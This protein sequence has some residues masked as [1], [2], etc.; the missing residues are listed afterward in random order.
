MKVLKDILY[1][2]GL[3]EVIGSTNI[4]I[5][6]ITFNSKEVK[7]DSLFVAVRGY[8][9]DGH[10]Y[11]SQAIEAGAIAI[12]CEDFPEIT[13]ANINYIKVENSALALGMIATNFYDNPSENIKLV[14][15]TGTNGK[16]TTVTL[17]YHLFKKLGYK[18]G[19]ISTVVNK[20]DN[21]DI[22]STHTTPDPIKLNALL[23]EMIHEG[24][25]Y[26]FM[27]VSSH[28]V[29]QKRIAGLK[30]SVAGFT[31]LSHDHLDYH[32][33]FKDYLL[34]KKAFF[35]QLSS[36]AVAITN[37]DDKNGNVMVQNTKAAVKSYALFSD[38][39]YKAKLIESH[40]SGL[41]IN[42]D[43][44]EIWSK[45]VGTFNAYNL[46]LVYGI[47]RSLNVEKLELLRIISLLESVEGRFQYFKSNNDVTVI[48]DYAH[49]PDAL[50][51]VLNSIKNLRTG[52]E[53]LITIV[54]C[55]GNRDAEKRP[56]MSNI[57][58]RFSNKVIITS[59]N[60]RNEDPNDIIAQM[61]KG[62]E[63]VDFK[64]TLSLVD[65][66]DAIKTAVMMAES[67]DIIL[68]AGKG[69]EKYQEISGVKYPFDDFEIA[70]ELIN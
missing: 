46:L 55:G 15:V 31:N 51:N 63:P 14:G 53:K 3:V 68:I 59:D 17:C 60:P 5:S 65:R 64:K 26:C 13:L 29:D 24:C 67:G 19:L 44:D 62:V 37:I 1:K 12:V 21:K 52:N 7:R 42:I 23:A 66:K 57:A 25:E 9:T 4:A 32:K 50:E 39:D 6:H 38:S 2:A 45:L 69:H 49:T 20:V 47:A 11:I 58:C 40:F 22:P 35:D 36:D 16:T 28:A 8:A 70:K 54:G 33:T 34:A 27:E 43:G 10:K 30:F 48:V 18:V 41:L 56:L 61:M